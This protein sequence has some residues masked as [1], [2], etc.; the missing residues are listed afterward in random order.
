MFNQF[1]KLMY[2]IFKT[3]N[4]QKFKPYTHHFYYVDSVC[5]YISYLKAGDEF[6]HLP[7]YSNLLESSF[8]HLS[9]YA[10]RLE[11]SGSNYVTL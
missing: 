10:N 8:I 7:Y 1:F 11:S 3:L 5:K 6:I 2:I 4:I 9:Y